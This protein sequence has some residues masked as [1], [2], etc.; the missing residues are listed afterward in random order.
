MTSSVSRLISL[1]PFTLDAEKE[2]I[3]HKIFQKSTE[4][5]WKKCSAIF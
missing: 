3:R 4:T 5:C 1:C 2:A